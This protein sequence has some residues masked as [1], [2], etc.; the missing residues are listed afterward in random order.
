MTKNKKVLNIILDF[1][2]T[3]IK[4]YVI[5]FIIFLIGIFLGALFVN[6]SKD[7]QKEEIYENINNYINQMKEKTNYDNT[8]FLKNNI[9]D[10]TIL[11][12]GLWFAGTTII[13]IPIVLFIVLFR[14]FCLGY[15]I[16]AC[17]YTMGT[18]K[19]FLFVL[20]SILLQNIIFIPA[21]ITL[22]VSGMRLYKAIIKDKRKGNIKLEIL[23]H[24]F[25]S[26]NMLLLLIFSV[27]VKVNI[28]G[29]LIQ[30][31]IKYF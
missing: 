24:T 11:A 21:L 18:V 3:N 13:G 12:I 25:L 19:G 22:S 10:N 1:I 6:N 15:T 23:K 14:G 20:I 31:L 2:K 27:I 16:S 9:K 28:S 4:Y 26:C 30:N 7:E 5:V 17:T 8:K 29:R